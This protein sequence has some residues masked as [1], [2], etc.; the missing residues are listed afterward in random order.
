MLLKIFFCLFVT[1][2]K[3]QLPVQLIFFVLLLSYMLIYSVSVVIKR[4]IF[5][6]EMEHTAVLILRILQAGMFSRDLIF[7]D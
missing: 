5:K 7:Y 2:Y 4:S 6:Q 3:R 1:F